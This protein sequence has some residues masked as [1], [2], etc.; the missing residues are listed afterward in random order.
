MV[1]CLDA[2]LA[3]SD[4]F[5][6]RLETRVRE[7]IADG[8][9]IPFHTR[10]ETYSRVEVRLG[11]T[12]LARYGPAD[13]FLFLQAGVV[14]E[15]QANLGG[16]FRSAREAYDMVRGSL[17]PWGWDV[18]DQIPFG[19][20]EWAACR[21]DHERLWKKWFHPSGAGALV[22]FICLLDGEQSEVFGLQLIV[23]APERPPLGSTP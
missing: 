19:E 21:R 4:A 16:S 9:S 20:S 10:A 6:I 8:W 11:S 17:A 14:S 1:A 12:V 15:A 23:K 2:P 22:S 13:V 18:P 7:G 5:S 3:L